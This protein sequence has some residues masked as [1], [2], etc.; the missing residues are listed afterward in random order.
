MFRRSV[1]QM[2]LQEQGVTDWGT[3]LKVSL[4]SS[5]SIVFAEG[6]GKG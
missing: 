4:Q 2:I 6:L 3:G 5:Y 1:L